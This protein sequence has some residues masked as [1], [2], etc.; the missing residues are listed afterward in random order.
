MDKLYEDLIYLIVE[1]LDNNDRLK[2]R[3]AERIFNNVTPRQ[4]L[5]SNYY[6]NM[7]EMLET[8]LVSCEYCNRIK[9]VNELSVLNP[10][11]FP[12]TQC[13]YQVLCQS[14]CIRVC[15]YCYNHELCR[16]DEIKFEC[17]RKCSNCEMIFNISNYE[18]KYEESEWSPI[19][20]MEII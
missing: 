2:A 19:S 9:C 6:R 20:D 10:S 8:M 18:Y 1:Y 11:E 5:L 7:H 15:P 16:Y 13:C 3:L 14:G 4:P 12:E 17:L